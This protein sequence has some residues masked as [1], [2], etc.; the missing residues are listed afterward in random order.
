M[1]Q[2]HLP[3]SLDEKKE[4]QVLLQKTV[5]KKRRISEMRIHYQIAMTAVVV[6]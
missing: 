2:N 5:V 3:L 6:I 4:T 1:A